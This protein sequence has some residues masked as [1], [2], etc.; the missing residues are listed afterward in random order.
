LGRAV[1][2]PGLA[3]AGLVDQA[4]PRLARGA[5]DPVDLVAAGPGAERAGAA[6]VEEIPGRKR[7]RIPALQ[8]LERLAAPVFGD[9]IGEGLAV[10]GG[11]V[12][13]HQYHG[14]AAS[15]VG[16]RVPAGVEVVGHAALGT[17]VD[18]EGDRVLA[19]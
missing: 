15:G 16:L 11:A 3:P 17:A 18:D 12:E 1:H 8:V 9:G 5:G 4:L 13:V 2:H 10:A 14:V 6:G 19:A 7:M